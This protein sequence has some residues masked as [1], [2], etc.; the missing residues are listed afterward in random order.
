MKKTGESVI[1]WLDDDATTFL[2]TCAP[3]HPTPYSMCMPET[4]PSCLFWWEEERGVRYASR[5]GGFV[6]ASWS[7]S[8]DIKSR[9][10][11]RTV[12]CIPLAIFFLYIIV[13]SN[14]TTNRSVPHQLWALRRWNC[15]E[16]R[17]SVLAMVSSARHTKHVVD[18]GALLI[19]PW[20]L[21]LVLPALRI[22]PT[23]YFIFTL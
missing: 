18:G 1:A 5:G 16:A 12:T 3:Q 19:I 9:R 17:N 15:Y 23:C 10:I 13:R 21:F 7:W 14:Q 2:L 11:K 6:R 20:L 8:R 4:H 22:A